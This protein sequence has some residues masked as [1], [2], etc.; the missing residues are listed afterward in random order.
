MATAGSGDVLT[1]I[2]VSLIS[3]GL[4]SDNAAYCGAFIHGLAGDIATKEFGARSVMAMDILQCIPTA[5]RVI[6]TT[7]QNA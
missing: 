4:T 5:L 2:V 7:A 1:G 6:E 3:Q